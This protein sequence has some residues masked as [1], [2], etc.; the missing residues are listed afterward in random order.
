MPLPDG[1]ENAVAARASRSVRERVAR[2]NSC[3]SSR[4]ER[5]SLWAISVVRFGA[6]VGARNSACQFAFRR[7]LLILRLDADD[8]RPIERRNETVQSFRAGR[9]WEPTSLEVGWVFVHYWAQKFQAPISAV[10]SVGLMR[11]FSARSEFVT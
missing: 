3:D 7:T 4:F 8:H 9:F 11:L 6:Q 5:L 1:E 2:Q 10:R